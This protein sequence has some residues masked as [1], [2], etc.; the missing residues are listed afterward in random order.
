MLSSSYAIY[1]LR[2]SININ[3]LIN[4]CL[5][6]CCVLAGKCAKVHQC[7]PN[8]TLS[9]LLL[10]YSYLFLRN[11]LFEIIFQL[12]ENLLNT[13]KSRWVAFSYVSIK[14]FLS[15]FEDLLLWDMIFTRKK[16]DVSKHFSRNMKFDSK[17][18]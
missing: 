8:G 12:Y 6:Y 15:K 4:K 14:L 3:I 7:K 10:S 1:C 11:M 17:L 5:Q 9:P 2:R 16:S 13:R 18:S